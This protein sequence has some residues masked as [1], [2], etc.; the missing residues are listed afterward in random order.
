M[1]FEL[2]NKENG[3]NVF[4]NTDMSKIKEVDFCDSGYRYNL[5]GDDERFKY[6]YSLLDC[7]RMKINFNE[8]TFVPKYVKGSFTHSIKFFFRMKLFRFI[9]FVFEL[10]GKNFFIEHEKFP[11]RVG[12]KD[13]F[14]RDIYTFRAHL[15]T[16]KVVLSRKA[17]GRLFGFDDD[18]RYMS[19]NRFDIMGVV[20]YIED[21]D[22]MGYFITR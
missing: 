18:N 4:S 5:N 1:E 22:Y 11:Y 20:G 7:L 14:L 8:Y 17:F 15:G 19:E 16:P 9:L 2:I 21:K 13:K 6:K 3:H 12:G 10:F